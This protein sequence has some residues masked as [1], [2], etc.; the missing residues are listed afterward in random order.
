M[1]RRTFLL[2]AIMSPMILSA[3]NDGSSTSIVPGGNKSIAP[4]ADPFWDDAAVQKIIKNIRLPVFRTQDFSVEHY[5]AIS[6]GIDDCLSAF[7]AAIQACHDAG[8]GRVVVPAGTW[9]VNGPITL[10]SNVNLHLES[11]DT[12]VLFG[13]NP[14]FYP[15]VLTQFEANPCYNYSPLLYAYQAD[16]IAVTGLG[17]FDG[18]ASVTAW[19]PWKG[20]SVNGY[21]PSHPDPMISG[22]QSAESDALKNSA[23]EQSY[24][25]WSGR[26]LGYTPSFGPNANTGKM[27]YLRPNFV[28][29]WGCD[30]VLIDGVTFKRSPMWQ[31]APVLCTNLTVRGITAES[32]GPNNDGCDPVCCSGVLIDNCTFNTGD[33]CIAIKSGR[34]GDGFNFS[35]DGTGGPHP[36]YNIVIQNSRMADGHGGVTLG[37]EISGGVYN[38]Y[39]QN[40]TMSSTNLYAAL[41]LKTNSGIGGYIRNIYMRNISVPAGTSTA[42]NLYGAILLD[43]N[44][45]GYASPQQTSGGARNYAI[46]DIYVSH[47]TCGPD[48]APLFINIYAP[49]LAAASPEPGQNCT[50]GGIHL[51]S[52]S[53]GQTARDPAGV[54]AVVYNLGVHSGKAGSPVLA[55][56]DLAGLQV[57][58]LIDVTVN[59]VNQS[60]AEVVS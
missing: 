60:N 8:G 57:P 21:V 31:V 43:G 38:V 36:S 19:W 16:N 18:Q 7:T 35:P 56:P 48:N 22:N 49:D 47:F 4:P 9:L 50:I 53:F 34:G 33:D 24:V 26:V 42:N 10:L 55:A 25:P 3:C 29:F 12:L 2:S 46:R 39:A 59:G 28:G 44:Y 1:K 27:S 23:D 32:L 52:S 58:T 45:N 6:G 14:A 30:V 20:A 54:A 13:T 17:T 15:T 40:I 41:R 51:R 37:S 11:A 5:G